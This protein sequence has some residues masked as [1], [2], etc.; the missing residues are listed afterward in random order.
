MSLQSV[1]AEGLSFVRGRAST[2]FMRCVS[3]LMVVLVLAPLLSACATNPSIERGVTAKESIRSTSAAARTP[4]AGYELFE[5]L[6]CYRSVRQAGLPGLQ[7]TTK[8][9]AV[10]ISMFI[11]K[12][13]CTTLRPDGVLEVVEDSDCGPARPP[14]PKITSCE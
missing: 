8:P 2:R 3:H 12:K 7:P 6:L 13:R 11:P 14:L 4:P 9:F 10:P 5:T 1:L